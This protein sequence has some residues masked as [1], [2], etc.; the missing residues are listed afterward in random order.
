MITPLVLDPELAAAT[1]P[2]TRNARLEGYAAMPTAE[3]A[4]LHD[5]SE[6]T[7]L[8]WQGAIRLVLTPNPAKVPA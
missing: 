5:L 6:A 7:A 2:A 8:K 1:D 3:F 4:A